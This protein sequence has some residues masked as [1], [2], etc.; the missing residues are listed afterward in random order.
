MTH[1]FP[2]LGRGAGVE[3]EVGAAPGHLT[4]DPTA[5]ALEVLPHTYT[6]CVHT[7]PETCYNENILCQHSWVSCAAKQIHFFLL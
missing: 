2:S 6:H 5:C 7:K 4:V 3:G 1:S